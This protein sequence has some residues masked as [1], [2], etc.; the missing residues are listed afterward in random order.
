MLWVRGTNPD[1]Q[2][3]SPGSVFDLV[4]CR[5]AVADRARVLDYGTGLETYKFWCGATDAPVYTFRFAPT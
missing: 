2:R 3:Y 4:A 5:Y 1:A